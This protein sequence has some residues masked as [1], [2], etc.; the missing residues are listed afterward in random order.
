MDGETKKPSASL[1][2]PARGRPWVWWAGPLLLV[3]GTVLLARAVDPASIEAVLRAAAADPLS[4]AAAAA[5]YAGAFAFRSW[6]WARMAPG[7]TFG[8]AWSAIHVSLA[9][10][11][12]L[13]LRLGEVLR[14]STA[15]RRGGLPLA[16]A[17]ATTVVLRSAD[18]VAVAALAV[19]LGPR[20]VDDLLGGLAWLPVATAALLWVGGTA[21][22]SRKA[23]GRIASSAVLASAGAFVG[24]VLESAVLWQAAHWAGIDLTPVDAVLVT[25]VTI[26]AQVFAVAPAGLGTY[27]AAGTAAFVAL[28][29][30]ADA[31][32]AA[33][34]TAH[35]LK[36]SYSLATGAAALLFPAPGA[37]GRLR[38]GPGRPP[39]CPGQSSAP[40]GP[41]ALVLPAHN[42]VATV[43]AVMGR[44][45]RA[46]A[47][48]PVVT[49]VIDDGSTDGTAR[50][51]AAAGAH[52]VSIGS[53]RGLGAAV[54]TGLE[55]AVRQGAAAVAFCDADGEYAPEELADVISPVLAG[56]AD[57]VVGTRF[58]GRIGRMLP[59]RRIGNIVLTRILSF[60]ARTSIT[61]G[62]SGYRALSRAA[63]ADAEI[64]HDY[65]YAQV[66]T[67]DLLAKGYRYA[68]VPI[69]YSFR[70]T[71]KTFVK[72]GRYLR[73]VIPAVH[74]EINGRT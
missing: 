31:A 39:R 17:T 52:V 68:E 69:S 27:E 37:L 12:I 74:R 3:A 7:L 6:I 45:P 15:V 28:G 24:W 23:R 43:G 34:I 47:G 73:A 19:L 4:I 33:A 16:T 8:H 46:I 62:Q 57:Y 49:I 20:V 25:A 21:W 51:A 70:T 71:G 29:A 5:A 61:D 65:N 54:R 38:L 1:P 66:L 72:L 64:V 58:G 22:L 36:T 26:A 42:E 41:I 9:A 59:H 50:V 48:R 55:E 44:T 67:L 13:P 60:L 56:E 14:V 10:N 32:L 18:I 30:D 35:A 63:A 53:N 40:E 11:H 2:T